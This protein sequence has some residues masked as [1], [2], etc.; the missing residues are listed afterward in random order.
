MRIQVGD[1]PVKIYDVAHN[2][3]TLTN[4]GDKNILLWYG[5]DVK[6]SGYP[7]KPGGSIRWKNGNA[8]WV[9]CASGESSYLDSSNG[10]IEFDAT[11]VAVALNDSGLAQ[12]IATD[13]ANSTL[14]QSVATD[15]EN[16]DLAEN[17]ANEVNALGVPPINTLTQVATYSG[18]IKGGQKSLGTISVANYQ[19]LIVCYSEYD[20]V[21]NIVY[22][23]NLTFEWE[24]GSSGI[25]L[26]QNLGIFRDILSGVILTAPPNVVMR[27]PV[28]GPSVNITIQP[29]SETGLPT[30]EYILTIYGSMQSIPNLQWLSFSQKAINDGMSGDCGTG[31]INGT[32]DAIPANG[33]VFI[34]ISTRSDVPL[35]IRVQFS[36][37]DSGDQCNVSIVNDVNPMLGPIT[38]DST[39]DDYTFHFDS[40]PRA[41]VDLDIHMLATNT[42]QPT[43]NVTSIQ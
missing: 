30:G 22:Q 23:R 24:T 20:E 33:E 14:A 3:V 10:Q 25:I 40:A 37:G 1:S 2:D 4:N 8:L 28:W 43:I 13:I 38:L 9:S 17:I 12:A 42:G 7:L 11:A 15:I 18:T 34:P 41:L 27:M 31:L 21:S 29:T 35:N 5:S 26:T 36:G 32:F 19:S 39:N 6:T 16:S